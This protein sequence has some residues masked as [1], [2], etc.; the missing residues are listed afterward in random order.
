MFAFMSNH[1]ASYS[2]SCVTSLTDDATN[3]R[4]RIWIQIYT[5]GALFTS[6][7][8]KSELSYDTTCCPDLRSD[9]WW[10]GQ[11]WR[12]E[13]SIWVNSK[14]PSMTKCKRRK[15]SET[16]GDFTVKYLTRMPSNMKSSTLTTQATIVGGSCGWFI[17][18]SCDAGWDWSYSHID[19]LKGLQPDHLPGSDTCQ[20]F[21]VLFRNRNLFL[22]YPSLSCAVLDWIHIRYVVMWNEWELS[23][24]N[25]WPFAAYACWAPSSSANTDS[26]KVA[27]RDQNVQQTDSLPSSQAAFHQD[28]DQQ[29][30]HTCD[31]FYF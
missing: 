15:E 6:I 7:V 14:L 13:S 26:H 16:Q 30:P 29:R 4:K 2:S 3:W 11:Q 22:S 27:T 8:D 25:S 28:D 18:P 24:W 9:L 1:V 17:S 20:I 23:D 21:S 12:G 31:V 5:L 19:E 10:D